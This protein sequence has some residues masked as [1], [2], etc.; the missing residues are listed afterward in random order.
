MEETV[1]QWLTDS[2]SISTLEITVELNVLH[3]ETWNV[4]HS[5]KMYPFYIRKEQFLS[6]DDYPRRE[7]CI[8]ISM[9]H[10]QEEGLD[11]RDLL[12]DLRCSPDLNPCD[13]FQLGQL[14]LLDY[15]RTVK[16]REDLVRG[17]SSLQH[18]K[19]IPGIFEH[20]RESFFR[21]CRLFND[22]SV[23]ITSHNSCNNYSKK[24]FW[25]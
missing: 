5:A 6:E 10:I 19:T 24:S 8:I 9:K 20:V 14:K 1:L 17:M 7:Q 21:R 11:V 12:H 13:F 16:T 15:A 18:I 3:T 2:L 25:S 23:D 4:L 22:V